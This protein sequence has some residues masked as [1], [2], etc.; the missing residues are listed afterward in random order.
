MSLPVPGAK[1]MLTIL[2]SAVADEKDFYH[3]RIASHKSAYIVFTDFPDFLDS[4]F[5]A[6]HLIIRHI[7][8]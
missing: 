2:Y 8:I 3:F 7:D 1:I 5:I 4:N 6:Y